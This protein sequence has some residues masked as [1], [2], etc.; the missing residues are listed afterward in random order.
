[1]KNE[2]PK[3]VAIAIIAL[4]VGGAAFGI[5]RATSGPAELPRPE[6]VSKVIPN[7]IWDTMD[8]AAQ[9]NSRK[10]GFIPESEASE[11]EKQRMRDLQQQAQPSQAPGRQ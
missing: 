7:Y 6:N 3:P 9:D 8:A 1:M 2:I 4:L 10:A 11:E 5:F